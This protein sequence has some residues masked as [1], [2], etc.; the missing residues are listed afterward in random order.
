MLSIPVTTTCRQGTCHVWY[1]VE[2]QEI[3]QW[4][5]EHIC[6]DLEKI[7]DS[8]MALFLGFDME[9]KPLEKHDKETPLEPMMPRTSVIQIAYKDS[10]LVISLLHMHQGGKKVYRLPQK[11]Q[12]ILQDSRTCKLGVGIVH[13]ACKLKHDWNIQMSNIFDIALEFSMIYPQSAKLSLKH[14][15]EVLT[16][17]HMVKSKEITL[18]DWNVY[19]LSL[20]QL[21]YAALDAWVA[22]E[23]MKQLVLLHQPVRYYKSSKPRK[24]KTG[25]LVLTYQDKGPPS[26]ASVEQDN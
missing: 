4:I 1:L 21:Q 22:Q 16:G 25:V 10:V 5:Q 8:D 17:Y 3:N 7:Q 2:E 11:L 24:K 9:W 12:D 19:P 13:D 23:C 20:P 14:V 18:S 6:Y 26:H 15:T